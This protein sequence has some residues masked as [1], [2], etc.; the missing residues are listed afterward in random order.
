MGRT[1]QHQLTKHPMTT[2]QEDWLPIEHF[3]G[4]EVSSLGRVRSYYGSGG[5]GEL[6]EDFRLLKPSASKDKLYL[7]VTLLQDGKSKPYRIHT[8]VLTTFVGPKPTPQH[9]GCH[10]DGDHTRNHLSNLRWGTAQDNADD[11]KKHGT[12]ICGGN[13]PHAVLTF[14]QVEEIRAALPTWKLGM[15][16][17]F[18]QKFGVRHTAI[19]K[20]KLNQTWSHIR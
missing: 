13:A 20:V 4:Y 6:R 12:H 5:R 19:S 2:T 15:G 18:A 14:E 11:R 7:R 10:G 8:L 9:V 3:P 1:L 17:Y 16:N